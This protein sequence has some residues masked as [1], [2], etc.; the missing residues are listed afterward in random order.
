MPIAL[1]RFT[2]TGREAAA[3]AADAAV[4]LEEGRGGEAGTD[5]GQAAQARADGS[6]AAAAPAR[7]ARRS[8]F[9]STLGCLAALL[10]CGVFSMILSAAIFEGA[11]ST[12]LM[13]MLCCKYTKHQAT[14]VL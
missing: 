3:A 14:F 8:R 4:V 1:L 10:Y 9:T 13:W 11:S 7:P 6:S 12:T 2:N 5:A